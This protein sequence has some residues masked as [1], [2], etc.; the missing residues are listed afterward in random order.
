MLP[1]GLAED[2]SFSNNLGNTTLIALAS[3]SVNLVF[4]ANCGFML[5]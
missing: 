5:P 4:S 1:A 2:S 3:S